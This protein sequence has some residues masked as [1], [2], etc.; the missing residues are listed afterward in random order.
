MNAI[1]NIY[2]NAYTREYR[3]IRIQSQ[4]TV[5]DVLGKD[6]DYINSVIMC[7]GHMVDYD[8]M[9]K[10]GDVVCARTYPSAATAVAVTALVVV[11]VAALAAGGLALACAFNWGGIRD[12]LKNWLVGD[13]DAT[14]NNEGNENGKIPTIR[15]CRNRP[16]L[17]HPV[18]VVLGR[19]LLTPYYCGNPFTSVS[20]TDGESQTYTVSFCVGYGQLEVTHIKLGDLVLSENTGKVENGYI[21]VSQAEGSAGRFIGNVTLHI[22][23]MTESVCAMYPSKISQE[24]LE[25]QLLCPEGTTP[26]KAERFSAAFP[27][28]VQVELSMSALYGIDDEGNRK[29]ASC[30]VILAISLDGGTS[31]IPFGAVAGASGSAVVPVTDT[32]GTVIG[33]GTKSVITR[34]KNSQMRFLATRELTWAEAVYLHEHGGDVAQIFMQKA[35][36]DPTDGKTVDGIYC[37]AIRTWVYDYDKSTA[38]GGFV[39]E[40][41]I[42]SKLRKKTVCLTMSVTASNGFADLNGTLNELTCVVAS[43]CRTWDGSR[44]SDTKTATCNPASV[45][46]EMMQSPTLGQYAVPDS[47]IDLAAFGELY[48]FAESHTGRKAGYSQPQPL[49]FEVSGALTSQKK[50]EDVVNQVLTTARASL[51]RNG[52]KYSVLIDKP[53]D[54][55]VTIL[56]NHSFLRDGVSNSKSFDELPDGYKVKFINERLGYGEDFIYVMVG[57]KTS[58]DP[59]AVI[60]ETEVLWIT[61]P[62]L[63]WQSVV[64]NHAKR[65]CRPETWSRKVGIDG[66]LIEIGSMVSIQDD[67]ILVGIGDGGEIKELLYNSGMTAIAGVAIDGEIGISD[68]SRE[69]GVKILVADGTHSPSVVT[70]K[71]SIPSEGYY[72]RFM[73]TEPIYLS[74]TIKPAVGDILSFGIYDRITYD[75]LCTSKRDNGDGT[76]DLQFVPYDERVYT[77]DTT[78]IPEFNSKMT[79]PQVMSE[80]NQVPPEYVKVSDY[81]SSI[82]SLIGGG[83]SAAVG[84]PGVPRSLSCVAVQNGVVLSWIQPS[85]GGLSG[86]VSYYEIELSRDGGETYSPVAHAMSLEYTY[87]FVG[88]DKY[89]EYTYFSEWKFRIR[90][91]SVYGK[92]SGWTESAVDTTSY[93]TWLFG[94]AVPDVKIQQNNSTG[95]VLQATFK[96]PARSDL[97]QL[98]GSIRYRVQIQRRIE[99]GYAPAGGEDYDGP[100]EWWAPSTSANPY[101]GENNYKDEGASPDYI[102]AQETYLQ[103]LPLAGQSFVGGGKTQN[104]PYRIRVCAE[105]EAGTSGWAYPAPFTAT[106]TGIY[107]LVKANE[108][109]KQAYITELSSICANLGRITGGSMNG[110]EFN[111]WTLETLVNAHPDTDP[112]KPVLNKDYQGAFQVGGVNTAT[113]EEQFLRVVPQINI[114]GHTIDGYE[115]VFK[116]G[117]F[118]ISSQASKL[119]GEFIVQTNET[120]LNRTRITPIGTF[121]ESRT[122]PESTDWEVVAKQD[123]GGILSEQVYSNNTLLLS[124]A[125]IKARRNEG[126]D[127]GTPYLSS[128][129]RVYHFDT[130]EVDG[131]R[132]LTGDVLDQ[133]GQTG[134]TVSVASGG[135]AKEV[136]SE[137]GDQYRPA[138]QVKAPYSEIGNSL[139]GQFSLVHSLGSGTKWTVDFWFQYT[140]AEGQELF[141][142]TASRGALYVRTETSEPNY[143]FIEDG[144]PPYNTEETESGAGIIPYNVA[145]PDGCLLVY[146][147]NGTEY[148]VRLKDIGIDL[149]PDDWAH[150]AVTLDGG[151]MTVMLSNDAVV[152]R[153][154]DD[155]GHEVPYVVREFTGAGTGGTFSYNPSRGTALIDELLVD[156]TAA[157]TAAVFGEASVSKIPWGALPA[158]GKRLMLIKD[159]DAEFI[160]NL[161]FAPYL[162]LTDDDFEEIFDV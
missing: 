140:W 47:K 48:E 33:T 38:S 157:E 137:Q 110:G 141:R 133:N 83:G 160:T 147:R 46:L 125:G 50:L 132:Q 130:D 41:L 86:T 18:P 14:S 113:G 6:F 17:G 7:N 59:T 9:I 44:W 75:V 37:T 102:V 64:Y 154:L 61:N 30:E 98:Y 69:Y 16:M 107:D 40:D 96:M 108:T 122:T 151:R 4:L 136:G 45:A 79:N 82:N 72:G 87:A 153:Y 81:M 111:Y 148:P 121:F 118:E 78:G 2:D 155:P 11:G 73:F 91:V 99:P 123:T 162:E 26:L 8:Y 131:T 29:D 43:K 106:V 13:S 36:T 39:L 21:P 85:Q 88:A 31:Y 101:D 103:T 74:E 42:D 128:A 34:N 95:R 80:V 142:A 53:R 5:G 1:L 55:P 10:D 66:N 3:T 158:E 105:N 156:A 104:T 54:Y 15:G 117:K 27:E 152:Q 120:S 129:S 20:G 58:T 84:N 19:T 97:R 28:K 143:S 65:V 52:N 127:I 145:R 35:N 90:T 161:N 94:Q 71:V 124:N 62:D 49:P 92:F 149:K 126:L 114:D 135:H 109:S 24:N 68:T 138:I 22:G 112:D 67:T 119:N 115:I 56:N 63:V 100:D 76:F 116:V 159:E 93:G 57:N 23:S 60:E 12:K 89:Q 139:A 146:E 150:C 51:T 77:A 134:L 32:A 25:F 70:R 144:V